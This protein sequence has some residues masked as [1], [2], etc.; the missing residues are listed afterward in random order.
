MYGLKTRRPATRFG[1]TVSKKVGDAVVRNR[2]RRRLR[3]ICRLHLA[4][5]APGWDVVFV[6]RSDGA[7]ASYAGLLQAFHAQSERLGCCVSAP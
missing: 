2:L 7:Q 6:A 4:A 1:F 3:E 5:F